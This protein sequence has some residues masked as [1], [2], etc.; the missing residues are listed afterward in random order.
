MGQKAGVCVFF[1]GA[2]VKNVT[3][4]RHILASYHRVREA[5][6]DPY[7]EIYLKF[8]PGIDGTDFR[9]FDRNLD[10]SLATCRDF[11]LRGDPIFNPLIHRRIPKDKPGKFRDIYLPT[12][13]DRVVQKAIADATADRLDRHFYPNLLS[14]RKGP[15][16]GTMA[17]ARKVRLFIGEQS[18]PV[19]LFKTDIRNYFDT[20]DHKLL[21]ARFGHYLPDE[22]EILLLIRSFLRQRRCSNGVLFSPIVG[23]PTGSPLSPLC[24]NL[25]LVDLDAALFRGGFTS[26]RYGDDILLLSVEKGQREKGRL[27]VEETLSRNGLALAREK[28]FIQDSSVPFDYLGYH[29]E[30]A[31]IDVGK[32]A[33]ARFRLWVSDALA[34][35]RYRPVKR[36]KGPERRNLLKRILQDLNAN[37]ATSLAL[38]RLPWLKGFP[39]VNSDETLRALDAFIKDRIRICITGRVSPKNRHEVPEAWFRE[40]GFQSLTSLYYRINRRRA[41]R[42]GR[43]WHGRALPYFPQG[44]VGSGEVAGLNSWKTILRLLVTGGSGRKG[45]FAD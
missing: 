24:A 35:S 44:T 27:L 28:T 21:L 23:I 4:P 43:G 32:G 7:F 5:F 42:I 3:D 19:F 30:G 15:A 13:R 26:I 8:V 2:L 37:L 38:R 20:M 36:G 11:L 18:G 17:A 16:F 41:V 34:R 14:Y 45:V 9:D 12:L 6:Y 1:L 22:P 33:S 29:F 40:A 39:V 31:K 25:F 10:D